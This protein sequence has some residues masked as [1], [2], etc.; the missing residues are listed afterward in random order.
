MLVEATKEALTRKLGGKSTTILK[1]A[2]LPEPVVPGM[3]ST[4]SLKRSPNAEV[5]ILAASRSVEVY[6]IP[7][8]KILDQAPE[9]GSINPCL[10]RPSAGLS[11]PISN[12]YMRIFF[13]NLVCTKYIPDCEDCDLE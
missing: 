1:S 2:L 6:P 9:G 5:S 11:V 7:L 10:D 8:P 13:Q 12:K 4:P 3:R